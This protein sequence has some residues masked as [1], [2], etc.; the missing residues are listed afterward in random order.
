MKTLKISIYLCILFLLGAASGFGIS[1]TGIPFAIRASQKSEAAIVDRLLKETEN[2]LRLTE[3]Q[4]PIARKTYE[5]M[6]S[7]IR[8]IRQETSF[9]IRELMMQKCTD[10]WKHLSPEQRVEFKKLNEERKERWKRFQP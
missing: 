2:R 10:L 8:E 1:K 7:G 3:D 4:K 6:A 9:K 5:E